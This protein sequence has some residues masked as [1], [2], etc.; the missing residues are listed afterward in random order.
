MRCVG[1]LAGATSL[2]LA[3][4]TAPAAA[5]DSKQRCVAAF[6]EGQRAQLTGDLQ[7]ASGEFESCA[8]NACPAAVQQECS[9]LLEAAG[10]A[11]P[12]V[13]FELSFGTDLSGRPVRLSV[14]AGEPRIYEDREVL[15][16]NPGKHRFVFQC[17]GCATV[18]RRMNFAEQEAKRKEIVLNPAC[19][20]TDGVAASAGPRAEA[21]P[22]SCPP[23][24]LGAGN[25]S[26][27]QSAPTPRASI[28]HP[29]ADDTG[30]R[31]TLILGSAATL[32]SLGA[33]GFVGFG[34]EARS[35]ERALRECTPFCSG[36]RIA[37]VKRSYVLANASLASGVLALGG[38]TIWWFGLRDSSQPPRNKSA[39]LGGW[40]I[41]LGAINKVTRTF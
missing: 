22:A 31:D 34:V 40:S 19:G 4:S 18:T 32:V 14:D 10:A 6:E 11:M 9:R 28:R 16:V 21:P 15:R 30:L 33:L 1:L 36:E 38:A 12:S 35:A 41:E 27:P 20:N 23:Q 29:A 24:K 3:L 13:Q 26:P 25:M 5:E 37:E 8:A 39:N 17:E 2:L 7:R